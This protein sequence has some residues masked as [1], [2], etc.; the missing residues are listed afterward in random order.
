MSLQVYSPN[1]RTFEKTR[2][3]DPFSQVKEKLKLDQKNV[4]RE[5]WVG[6]VNLGAGAPSPLCDLVSS[7]VQW[8]DWAR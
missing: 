3:H 2:S 5:Q 1:I 4:K 6:A 7:A 8:T